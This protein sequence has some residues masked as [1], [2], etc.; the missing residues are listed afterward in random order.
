MNTGFGGSADTRTR[1]T[2]ELQAT[3]IREL[4]SGIL[5]NPTVGRQSTSDVLPC[6]DASLSTCMPEAWVRASILIR[7]NSLASGHSGVR[8]ILIHNMLELLT[9]DIIPRIPLRGS[10]SAS[11]DL[12]PL[13]YIGG[14]LEGKCGLTVWAGSRPNRRIVTA[15]VA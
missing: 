6:E 11:G 8:P 7:V 4:H 10:I 12:M 1:K 13:S 15:D 5:S 9:K 14:A 2:K 3:L